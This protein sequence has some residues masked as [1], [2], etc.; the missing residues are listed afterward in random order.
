MSLLMTIILTILAAV[1][2]LG[3]LV[4]LHEFGHYIV[5]RLCGVKVLTYSIGFGPK[6]A[7]WTSKKS[8]IDYR[9]SALPLGGY[10]KMLDGR[11][12]DVPKGQ[13]HL[14]FDKQ[15]PMKKI[16]IV[17]A[18]PV[19]NLLIAMAL[20]W[21]LFL[22]PS[23]QLNTRIGTI[24]PN[25]PAATAKLNVGDKITAVDGEAVDGWEAI[26]YRLANHMGETTQVT[27]T[28]IPYQDDEPTA[29]SIQYQ[30]PITKF[31]QG[32]NSGKDALT[33]IGVTP[34]QPNIPAVIGQ[35]SDDGAAKRQGLQIGDK[36][37]AIND[38]PINDWI[39]MTRVV[40]DNPE[41]LLNF[42]VLRGDE[43]MTFAV[44]P[45]GKK[46]TMGNVYGQIGAGV[47]SVDGA[48]DIQVPDSYKTTIAYDPVTAMGKAVGK[49]YD[50]SMMTLSSMGKMITGLIG[51]DNL[52]GPITIAKV[53]KQSFEISWQMV[54][55]TA[56]LIS[57]SLA[58]LNL[59]PIPVLDGGHLLYYFI[60]L[61]RGKP[62]SETTQN[63]GFN[64]GFLLLA[65]FMV[66]ALS[67]DIGRLF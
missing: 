54:L 13:E 65:V 63:I 45:Q 20:F 10:V 5:A 56:G 53:A 52:S 48:V 25:S 30:L 58:V 14:A 39:T 42:K 47:N 62:L 11:E 15:H 21:V 38:E 16:A 31:M 40:Q 46:D 28:V 4:A 23:E 29:Q 24:L 50:L 61:I 12:G 19:T 67:V 34:W 27:L 43:Q 17:A 41:K 9:L 44:M 37:I 49:T 57:L 8:G 22:T 18:G 7:S 66:M 36:I 35:L 33:A 64:L 6:L 55:S 51:I 32:K 60:E 1:F 26:N 2:V 3:P 59:L